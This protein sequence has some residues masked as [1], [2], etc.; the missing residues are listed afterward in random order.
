MQ[1]VAVND[2]LN[3]L[4]ENGLVIGKASEFVGNLEFDLQVKR[5]QLKKQKAVTFKQ[6]LDAKIL[7]VKSKT[8]L[9]YWIEKGKFKPGETY[10]CAKTNRIMIL[11]SALVRL[12]YL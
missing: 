2:F 4:K 7:P 6:V 3:H 9:E 10:K 1:V 12:N 8:A 11:T 5:N